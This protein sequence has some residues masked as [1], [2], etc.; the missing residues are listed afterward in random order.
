VVL[1]TTLGM[2]IADVP[3]VFLGNSFAKRL[4]IRLIH[5]IAASIFTILGLLILFKAEQW[6]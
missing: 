2:M 5:T 3:A 6:F 1:G 4:P